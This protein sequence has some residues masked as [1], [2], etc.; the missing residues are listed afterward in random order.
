M[1][2]TQH[3]Q[4][5]KM[6]RWFFTIPALVLLTGTLASGG[7]IR[8]PSPS[9]N[10]HQNQTAFS[11]TRLSLEVP[12]VRDRV[13]PFDGNNKVLIT[14]FGGSLWYHKAIGQDPLFYKNKAKGVIATI[15]KR[16]IDEAKKGVLGS[17]A[18]SPPEAPPGFYNIKSKGGKPAK[19]HLLGKRLGGSG[20]E[21]NNIVAVHENV[22]QYVM[23]H[24]ENRIATAYDLGKI[25]ASCKVLYFGLPHYQN[26]GNGPRHHPLY[27][28][29]EAQIFNKRI[30]QYVKWFKVSVPNEETASLVNTA[31]IH[32]HEA[33]GIFPMKC[34]TNA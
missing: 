4:G 8:P 34:S 29:V 12:S 28:L 2:A 33:S 24:F 10:I 3:L 6:D 18:Y 14:K 16:M 9:R 30:N 11:N 7:D 22:K 27:I 19:G 23:A 25:D 32:D 31:I 17:Y 21:Y 5:S 26:E 15:T 1:Y 20:L 13:T